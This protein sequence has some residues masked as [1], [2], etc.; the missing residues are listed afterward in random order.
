MCCIMALGM[1][2]GLPSWKSLVAWLL[3]V[4]HE[5]GQNWH[6]CHLAGSQ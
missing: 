2:G 6:F 4:N 3:V 1:F 5:K